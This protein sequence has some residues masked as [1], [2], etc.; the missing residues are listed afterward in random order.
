MSSKRL[1]ELKKYN[2]YTLALQALEFEQKALK[3]EKKEEVVWL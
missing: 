2:H 3:L 1:R